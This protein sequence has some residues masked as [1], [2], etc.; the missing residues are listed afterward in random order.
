MKGTLCQS[1][2]S[3]HR[4]LALT[5]FSLHVSQSLCLSSIAL[6]LPIHYAVSGCQS[7]ILIDVAL[8]DAHPKMLYEDGVQKRSS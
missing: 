6:L 2:V 4:H 5:Q 1:V 3:R 8:R 7:S